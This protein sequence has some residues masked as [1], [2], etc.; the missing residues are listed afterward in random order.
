MFYMFSVSSITCC[1]FTSSIFNIIEFYPSILIIVSCKAI[2]EEAKSF[3]WSKKR[4][5]SDPIHKKSSAIQDNR[6]AF[7]IFIDFNSSMCSP[8][9]TSFLV[10]LNANFDVKL[11]HIRLGNLTYSSI[12]SVSFLTVLPNCDC[13]CEICSLARQARFSFSISHINLKFIFDLIHIYIWGPYKLL[14]YNN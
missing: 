14:T 11:W 7:Q 1:Q 13:Q 9:S 10:R 12:K 8:V 6:K 5:L 2:N 4:S 3:L